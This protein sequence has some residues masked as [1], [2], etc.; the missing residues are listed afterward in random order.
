MCYNIMSGFRCFTF[1]S[2][3]NSTFLLI[4]LL[5][6]FIPRQITC[7][8]IMPAF[9]S[10]YAMKIKIFSLSLPAP[11]SSEIYSSSS[12]SATSSSG[13]I[14][15][16]TLLSMC[17]TYSLFRRY[18]VCHLSKGLLSFCKIFLKGIKGDIHEVSTCL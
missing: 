9:I 5:L 12:S 11:P 2:I 10:A 14:L 7:R 15:R 3:M 16:M 18:R 4:S 17:K 8:C 1:V 6:N 13:R